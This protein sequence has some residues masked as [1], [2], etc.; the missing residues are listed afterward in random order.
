MFE[1]R[2]LHREELF[3]RS[4]DMEVVWFRTLIKLTMGALT[5]SATTLCVF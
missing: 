2:G 4:R 5:R 3:A 1:G